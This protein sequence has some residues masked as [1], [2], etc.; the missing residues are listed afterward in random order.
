VF[1]FV[2]TGFNIGASVAP[3]IYGMLMDQGH[4]RAIFMLSAAVSIVCISTV[5]IGLSRREVR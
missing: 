5:T 3:I 1:G 4:P 2:S